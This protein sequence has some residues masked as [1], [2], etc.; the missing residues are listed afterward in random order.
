MKS[1]G[2][3]PAVVHWSTNRS[4]I[5]PQFQYDEVTMISGATEDWSASTEKE[6]KLSKRMY[7]F[8]LFVIHTAKSG[9]LVFSCNRNVIERVVENL[10]QKSISRRE[11]GSEEMHKRRE[12][13]RKRRRRIRTGRGKGREEEG[14]SRSEEEKQKRSRSKQEE[15]HKGLPWVHR[16][17]R[18]R[19][20]AVQRR[21][22]P[23]AYRNH[24]PFN[25]TFN[26]R[27]TVFEE[28]F[29]IHS[30]DTVCTQDKHYADPILPRSHPSNP[31][32]R[33]RSDS[34]QIWIGK[35][36]LEKRNRPD[37][38]DFLRFGNK[39]RQNANYPTS[40]IPVKRPFNNK[41]WI[42]LR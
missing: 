29:L 35:S 13:K 23:Q 19:W 7:A 21:H 10:T 14:R 39:T 28:I 25:K 22:L 38:A 15:Q 9:N 17:L 41:D 33:K 24:Q 2:H 26:N 31:N 37:V 1:P 18:L 4:N 6:K 16:S 34:F 8:L 27:K 40:F 36:D 32:Q 11:R 12:A 20:V 3:T 42:K 30:S 5:G